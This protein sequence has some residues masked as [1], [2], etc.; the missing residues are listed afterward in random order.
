MQYIKARQNYTLA[1]QQL[2]IL[3]GVKPDAAVD[4]LCEIGMHC[5]PVD[6]LSLDEVLSR[7]ADYAGTHV[8]IA[9]SEAQRKAAL[10]Q[11]NPQLSMFLAT[12]WDTVSPIWDKTCP[13]R[14]LRESNLNIPIFPMGCTLQNQPPAKAYIGIQ[15]LQQ[16]YVADTIFSRPLK[17]AHLRNIV[18]KQYPADFF[19]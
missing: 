9:R 11:Y 6:L 15:K 12:G 14:P 10:S 8:S 19:Q 18:R 2:N 16:S 13:I 17:S 7:R 1:L 5:P 3:M 4:S